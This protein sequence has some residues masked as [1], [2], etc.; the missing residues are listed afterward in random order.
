MSAHRDDSA[1]AVIGRLEEELGRSLSAMIEI[2]DR[3]NEVCVHCYQ[4]QG[5]KGEMTTEQIFGVID[6]LANNGILLLTISGGEVL[7]RSDFLDIVAHARKRSFLIRIFTNGLLMDERIASELGRLAVETVEISLYSHMAET[8]DFVTGVPNSFSRTVAGIRALI[9]HGVPVVVKT[10]I[11]SVNEHQMEDYAAFVESLGARLRVDP[12]AMMPREGGSN[13]PWALNAGD[14]A[15]LSLTKRHRDERSPAIRRRSEDSI[16]CG[17]GLGVHIEPNG[18]LRPCTILEL[19]LGNVKEHGLHAVQA[20]NEVLSGLTSIRYRDLHGCRDCEISGHCGR[21]F[22][23][24]LAETGDAL[25]P[26]PS[27][28]K[29]ARLHYEAQEGVPLRI[30]NAAERGDVGPYRITSHSSC[31]VIED[32]ISEADERLAKK[33]GWVRQAAVT[34]PVLPVRR[35]EL[36]QL[37][38]PGKA[39]SVELRVPT[40]LSG[41]T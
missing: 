6:D 20:N 4:V 7:L 18:Q 41:Q 8:H 13:A 5:Q 28:C 40:G 33:L 34:T 12:T 22:A 26:Y 25:G 29:S 36:V 1:M 23:Q 27:A 35:G 31:M 9:A 24:A 2:S 19:D 37:R 17:A 32:R 14:E 15:T 16:S 39:R 10:P 30:E 38:R 21:C 11:M 3:C